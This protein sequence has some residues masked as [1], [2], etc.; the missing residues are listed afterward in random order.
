MAYRIVPRTEWGAKPAQGVNANRTITT[1]APEV[2]IHHTV[3]SVPTTVEGEKAE[4]RKLQQ[5]GINKAIAKGWK[6]RDISYNF[7]VFPSGRI[8]EG[9]GFGKYGI[10]TENWNDKGHSI[11]HAGNYETRVPTAAQI[12]ATRWLIGEGKRLK[13][14]TATARIRGHRDVK[15]TACPGKNLYAKLPVI[16]TP[17]VVAPVY[18]FDVYVKGVRIATKNTRAEAVTLGCSKLDPFGGPVEIKRRK[19]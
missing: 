5:I 3:S 11:S 14:I 13:K 8:Y 12:D 9:R 17:L 16:R 15:A 19:V 4:M 7:V 1:P 18:K 10:H 6:T 2:F